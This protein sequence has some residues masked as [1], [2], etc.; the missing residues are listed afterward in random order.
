VAKFLRSDR[1]TVPQRGGRQITLIDLATNT[2]GL[3][4]YFPGYGSR[5]LFSSDWMVDSG[6]RFLTNHSL[7]HDIGTRYEYGNFGVVLLGHAL[8]L[9]AG[10]SY[11]ELVRDRIG[12]PL[13]MKDTAIALSADM[14]ARLAPGHDA[15]LAPAPMNKML[16]H[17]RPGGFPP[18]THTAL[19]WMVVPTTTGEVAWHAGRASGY[20]TF[21]G[22]DRSKG[23]GVVVLS[24]GDTETGVTDLGLHLLDAQFPLRRQ[25]A[26][27][28]VDAER[29]DRY[30]GRYDY[31]PAFSYT[32]TREDKRLFIQATGYLKNEMFAKSEHEFFLKAMH[33]QVVFEAGEAGAARALVFQNLRSG[34]D[35][36]AVRSPP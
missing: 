13:G 36:R 19:G 25:V 27:I 14:A 8:A 11:E 30:V 29:L 21:A 34:V 15:Q 20:R 3:P 28:S 7:A 9:K 2:S 5:G 24:N 22:I 23:V 17:R 10:T 12:T 1:V 26:E 33:A 6:Y 18:S 4:P 31:S 16:E 32:I 35:S